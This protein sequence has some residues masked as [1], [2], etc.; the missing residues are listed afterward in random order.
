M[1]P[2]PLEERI[3][4]HKFVVNCDLWSCQICGDI[5]TV[6]ICERLAFFIFAK[7]VEF[8]RMDPFWNFFFTFD[9]SVLLVFFVVFLQSPVVFGKGCV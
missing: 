3:D 4:M 7:R 9:L 5:N 8:G 2:E 6:S 1:V